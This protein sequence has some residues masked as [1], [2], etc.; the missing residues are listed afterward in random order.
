MNTLHNLFYSP[1]Q[2]PT[3]TSHSQFYNTVA[4]SVWEDSELLCKPPFIALATCEP[5]PAGENKM[6]AWQNVEVFYPGT[7]PCGLT[8]LFQLRKKD[9]DLSCLRGIKLWGHYRCLINWDIHSG[10]G[11]KMQEKCLTSSL[12]ASRGSMFPHS[13]CWPMTCGWRVF[14]RSLFTV[15]G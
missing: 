8:S 11:G 2:R 7:D 10:V 13:H 3:S 1:F 14:S 5:S 9:L 12:R 6:L 15:W 4:A